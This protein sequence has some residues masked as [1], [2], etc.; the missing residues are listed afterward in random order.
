MTLKLSH[1]IAGEFYE[2]HPI[3][4]AP[5]INPSTESVIKEVVYGSAK[6]VDHA[7]KAAADAF[8]E[9][10]ATPPA[11]R[12]KVLM[13]WRVLI[14]QH[15]D[16]LADVIGAEHGKSKVE[17]IGSITRGTDVLEYACGIPSS[18][19]GDY[20]ANV[21]RQIDSYSMRQPLGVV[22]AITPFNFPAMIPLWI[23]SVAIACGNTVVLKPSERN[24]SCAILLAELAIKAGL[25]KGVFNV[26]H[27]AKETVNALLE[28]PTIQ[29][30]SFVGQTATA[31][32]IQKTAIAN[33]KRVQAF[34]G[35]KNHALV[36]PDIDL[37][38]TT[39]A[40]LGAAYGSTGERCMAISAV[41]AVGDTVA[42]QL[43]EQLT[44]KI[45]ALKIG[46]YTEGAMEMGPLITQE[47]KQKVLAYIE[48]GVTQGAKL[49]VDGRSSSIPDK[50]Y[51]LGGCLFDQVTPQMSIYR[52]E[53]FGPVLVVM[54]VRSYEE[55]LSLINQ[56]QYANGVAI[57]TRDGDTARDFCARVQ[58]GMVGVNV[59]I[60]VPVGYHSF[61]G[62]KRSNFADHG[63]HGMEGVRFFTKLKTITSRWPSGIRQGVD[64]SLPT[65]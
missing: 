3:R 52:E 13:K 21:G 24:P 12:A 51:F 15:L 57:F 59:P 65:L 46:C 1:F 10:A 64:F 49:V 29:A 48:A 4:V 26:V 30:I 37:E 31:E 60:P 40:I 17:A 2:G 58:V 39:D 5:I 38:S 33:G 47:H 27:G 18:L 14:E 61:G 43:I 16:Q 8:P 50:G 36:M 44:P 35:A 20:S 11:A 63:M 28:H 19:M 9:W 41:I 56:H 34:G 32:Y 53:I 22:A 7:T 55:G 25:P 6:D 45:K 42:D 54:R 23:C 62:W